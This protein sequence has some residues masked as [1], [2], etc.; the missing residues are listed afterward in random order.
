MAFRINHIHYKA[1]DP[2]AS[3]DWFVKAFNFSIMTDETRGT[4]DRFIRAMSEDNKLQVNFSGERTGEPLPA[5]V[6]G[7][8]LGLEHI[9]IDSTDIEIDV[10]RLKALG[11]ELTEGPRVGRGGQMVAFMHTPDG[12]RVELMQPPKQ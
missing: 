9:G 5:G 10:A 11:A 1:R 6:V 12:F 3:A 4:G 7:P 8:H 2:K